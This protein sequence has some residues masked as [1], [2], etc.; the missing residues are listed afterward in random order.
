MTEKIE[1]CPAPDCNGRIGAIK[2]CDNTWW[3]Q[4]DNP[5]CM[6]CIRAETEDKAIQKA[7]HLCRLVKLGK[8]AL[9]LIETPPRVSLSTIEGDYRIGI[10]DGIRE[11]LYILKLKAAESHNEPD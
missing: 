10:A 11:C 5:H 8:A 4:C 9:E 7:H 1:P 2:T 6:L 3:A